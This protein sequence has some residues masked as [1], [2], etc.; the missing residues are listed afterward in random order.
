MTAPPYSVKLTSMNPSTSV[1]AS[2]R[3]A[4]LRHLEQ[5]GVDFEASH[6]IYADDAVLEFPQSGERF[7]G[8]DNF[9]AWRAIYPDPVRLEVR[10]ITGSGDVWISECSVSYDGGPWK[11]A[12][13]IHAFEGDK[14]VSERLY[15]MEPWPAP[16]WRAKWRTSP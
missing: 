12:V 9:R 11:P 5:T 14:L 15:T 1:D 10:R 8:L 13:G 2:R 3:A 4:L 7:E 16:E 6:E